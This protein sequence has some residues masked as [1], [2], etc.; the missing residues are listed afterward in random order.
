MSKG[1]R[2]DFKSELALVEGIFCDICSQTGEEVMD[3]LNEYCDAIALSEG[4]SASQVTFYQIVEY[5]V[6]MTE[7]DELQ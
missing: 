2:D 6:N 7:E 3:L 5:A 4:I 1:K